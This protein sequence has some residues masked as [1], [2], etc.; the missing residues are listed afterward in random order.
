MGVAKPARKTANSG[1]FSAT[2]YGLFPTPHFFMKF[3]LWSVLEHGFRKTRK[4]SLQTPSRTWFLG[5]VSGAVWSSFP[6]AA[7]DW[8]LGRGLEGGLEGGLEQLPRSCSR[9]PPDCHQTGAMVWGLPPDQTYLAQVRVAKLASLLKSP[10][11]VMA[12]HDRLGWVE[13]TCQASQQ[14]EVVRW[15]EVER[16]GC[17]GEVSS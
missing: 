1:Q 4:V 13:Q 14:V 7:P 10:Q 17:Q 12:C 11:P 6:G 5:W 15:G 16:L 2:F 8:G 9:L 3:V